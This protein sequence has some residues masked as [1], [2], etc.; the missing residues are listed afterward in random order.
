[1]TIFHFLCVLVPYVLL[2]AS[3][4]NVYASNGSGAHPASCPIGARDLSLAVKR[5]GREAEQSPPSSDE[6]NERVEIYFY[7]PNTPSWCG[8]QLKKKHRDNFT[9]PL[10]SSLTS[11]NIINLFIL[12]YNFCYSTC[13]TKNCSQ[14]S[15]HSQSTYADLL[16]TIRSTGL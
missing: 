7:S 15:I 16:V 9:L 3:I 4:L 8:A 6:V 1:M 5:P 2:R 10:N 12:K 11:L 14:I 13:C